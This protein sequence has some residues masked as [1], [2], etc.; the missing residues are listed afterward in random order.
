MT[1][2]DA[3]IHGYVHFFQAHHQSFPTRR[4]IASGVG[5]KSVGSLNKHLE[6]MVRENLLRI[7]AVGNGNGIYYFEAL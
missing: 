4:E 1:P 7:H 5:L 2:R 6:R 3:E